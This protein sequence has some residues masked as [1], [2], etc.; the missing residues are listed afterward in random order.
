MWTRGLLKNNAR[1]AFQ[2][3]YVSCLLVS[4][5]TM[6]LGGGM[7]SYS[8]GVNYG[9]EQ[10]AMQFQSYEEMYE[11]IS[12][13]ISQIPPYMIRI[14]LISFAVAMVFAYAVAI[15]VSNVVTVGC[16]RFFL[17]NR[18]HK[19]EIVKMFYGFSNGRYSKSVVTMFLRSLYVFLWSILFLIPGII[20]S[21]AYM[22]V[23]YILAENPDLDNKRV[24][25]LSEE[26]MRGHK[27][28]AFVLGFSFIGWNLISVISGGIV[29][30]FYVAPYI[31]ATY[32]EYYTALKAE[33]KAKG[34]FAPYELP[35]MGEAEV[36]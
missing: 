13:L 22:L 17:E 20:K 3:N 11:Y 7:V 15:L 14:F 23:P 34:L 12:N 27:W 9:N 32:A 5:I 29:G 30:T 28:E 25:A 26:M 4:L 36:I 1:V 10:K 6:I 33:A 35:G 8:V 16:N 18:E 24:F 2:R 31:N 19:T 21:Y